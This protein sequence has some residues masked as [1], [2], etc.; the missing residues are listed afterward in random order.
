MI[1]WHIKLCVVTLTIIV[2]NTN[3]NN[4]DTN[5]NNGDTNNNCNCI[6][7]KHQIS[8][9]GDGCSWELVANSC[10]HSEPSL[11]FSNS[12]DAH[13]LSSCSFSSFNAFNSSEFPLSL[14]PLQT[15]TGSFTVTPS[16]SIITSLPLCSKPSAAGE[17]VRTEPSASTATSTHY[18]PKLQPRQSLVIYVSWAALLRH[19]NL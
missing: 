14:W 8:E 3:N 11:S 5:N 18:S 17:E 6:L 10:G 4:D 2:C 16:A 9:L 12:N 7:N 19:P 1:C 15:T 13:F